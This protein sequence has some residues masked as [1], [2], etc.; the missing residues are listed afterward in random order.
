[1]IFFITRTILG[2]IFTGIS[3]GTLAQKQ[4]FFTVQPGENIYD[5]VPKHDVYEYSDFLP[6]YVIFK[7][8]VRSSAK[9]NYNFVHEDIQF[10]S[11]KG[12][13]LVIANAEEVKSVTIGKDEYYYTPNRFVKLDTVVGEARI[14]IAGFFTT[15]NRKRLSAYGSTIDGGVDSYGSYIV[16]ANTK[17]NLVPNVVTTVAYR[18]AM[19]IGNRFNYFVPVSKKNIFSFYPDKEQQ[20]RKF[21]NDNNIDFTSREDV[22]K[23]VNYMESLKPKA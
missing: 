21:L 19:F 15:V 1:M 13:T 11:S 23:L 2:V 8:G 14:G 4:K 9:F 3:L 7:N 20:L 16:P 12:D 6:G 18:K 17:L 22:V 5:V 10:I